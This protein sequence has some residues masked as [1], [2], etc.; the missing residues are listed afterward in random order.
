MTQALKAW[1]DGVDNWLENLGRRMNPK[2]FHYGCVCCGMLCSLFFFGAFIAAGFIP[3]ISPTWGPER[4]KE[5]YVH[6]QIGM[7]IGAILMMCSGMFFIP[8][9]AV[10]SQQMRRIPNIPWI[11]TTM[12][13]AAGAANVWT[14]C[15]PPMVLAVAAYRMD[16]TPEMFQFMN[17][18]FWLFATMPFQTFIPVSWTLA[19]AILIDRRK[20]PLYPKYM[21]L[22]NFFAPVMFWWSMGVHIV[23]SGVFSWNGALGF[24]LPAVFFGATFSGDTY[25]MFKAIKLEYEDWESDERSVRDSEEVESST[26]RKDTR[27]SS[28][29]IEQVG[30]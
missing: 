25:F 16:R 1:G 14:F 27:G 4:V 28:T 20:Q 6:H 13:L 30:V 18:M 11:L 9:V 17:D 22:L 7:H 2:Y 23:H 8:Y 15:V 29:A 19:Y 3:P 24:W 10:I 21:A 26:A 12:Q 5:H